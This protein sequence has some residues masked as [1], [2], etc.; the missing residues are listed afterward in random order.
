M[1]SAL[2]FL[3]F[4]KEDSV[5]PNFSKRML[6]SV[7]DLMLLCLF[8]LPIWHYLA[9]IIYAG[10]PPSAHLRNIMNESIKNN[11]PFYQNPEYNNF[12]SENLWP[13][14]TEKCIPLILITPIMLWCWT[15]YKTTP[16]KALLSLRIANATDLKNPSFFQLVIRVISCAIS[17]L[18]LGVGFITTLFNKENRAWHDFLSGTVVVKS[19][20]ARVHD[21]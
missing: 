10:P 19:N 3:K 6:S 14:L 21:K 17:V 12:I 9:L 1:V 11:I 20:T 4:K 16:G 2:N 7:I 8:F 15:K 13:L 18:P 5:Y